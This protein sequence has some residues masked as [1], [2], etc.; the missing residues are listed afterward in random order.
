MWQDTTT[1]GLFGSWTRVPGYVRPE[2][3]REGAAAFAGLQQCGRYYLLLDDY[4]QY[5]AYTTDAIL[6]PEWV[7]AEFADFPEGLKHGAVTPLTREE[8]EAVA[9]AFGA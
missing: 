7:P 5:L 6:E 3:P 2:T 8:Y 4:T 9:A 1:E